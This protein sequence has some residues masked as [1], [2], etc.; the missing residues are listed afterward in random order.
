MQ[1]RFLWAAALLASASMAANASSLVVSNNV[2]A[3]SELPIPVDNYF[4]GGPISVTGGPG[5][6]YTWS[7]TNGSNQGGSVFGYNLGIWL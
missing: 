6:G 4:G 3:S 2:T 5:G 1:V 7:S